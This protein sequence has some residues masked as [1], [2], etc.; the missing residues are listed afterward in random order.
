MIGPPIV[1]KLDF[2]EPGVN[3]QDDFYKLGIA[4]GG[5]DSGTGFTGTFP[6]QHKTCS[7]KVSGWTHTKGNYA[8]V[9]NQYAHLSNLLRSSFLRN[10][11]GTMNIEISGLEPAT[12]YIIKTY[13][14]SSHSGATSIMQ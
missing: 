11:A 1:A 6:C 5:P 9:T 13:H 3:P 8:P 10:S 14:H 12:K 4:D 2:G 7:V